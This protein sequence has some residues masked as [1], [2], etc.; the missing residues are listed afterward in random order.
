[1]STS[2]QALGRWG[3]AR[4]AEY[5]IARG[6]AIVE[7]NVRT[8][9]GEIDLVARREPTRTAYPGKPAPTTVFVEVKTRSSKAFGFP[10]ESVTPRKQAHLLAAAQSYIQEHPEFDGDWRIDVIAIQRD[11]SKAQPTITHFENAV[12]S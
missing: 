1:M 12:N 5:L 10:E 2:R 4:A 9:Y 7:R 8:P 11:P 3:E 6:Y